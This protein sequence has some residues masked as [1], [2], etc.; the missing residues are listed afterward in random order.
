[1]F[2][3]RN[4]K[5][6]TKE[7]DTSTPTEEISKKQIDTTLTLNCCNT[8]SSVAYIYNRHLCP[9][10]NTQ[11]DF[12]ISK[13]IVDSDSD[14]ETC[15]YPDS[16]DGDNEEKIVPDHVYDLSNSNG[17]KEKRDNQTMNT[18]Y[19]LFIKYLTVYVNPV[20]VPAFLTGCTCAFIYIQVYMANYL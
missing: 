12:F 16:D 2:L 13:S 1:M 18:N 8:T 14:D 5:K 15:V 10:C 19:K 11:L 9:Y 7:V 6:P 20:T 3:F 17:I 4:N